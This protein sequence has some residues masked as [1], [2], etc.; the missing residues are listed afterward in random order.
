MDHRRSK[1]PESSK[2]VQVTEVACQGQFGPPPSPPHQP[3]SRTAGR[4]SPALHELEASVAGG[5]NSQR[6]M[7]D[8]SINSTPPPR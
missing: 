6:I 4:H 1:L 5:S 8:P 7:V 3:P 2:R